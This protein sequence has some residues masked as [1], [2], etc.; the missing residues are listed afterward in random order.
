MKLR[1]RAAAL[2]HLDLFACRGMPGIR[3]PMPH[4]PGSDCV[5]EI[6]ELGSGVEGWV[7]GQRVLVYP[8]FVDYSKGIVEI[9][10]EIA[11]ALASFARCACLPAPYHCR[12]R[13][14][15]AGGQL[16][17][18][19]G[20]AHRM[21]FVRT[22]IRR[23]ETVLVLGASGGVGNAVVLAKLAGARVIA[24]AGSDE[25]CAHLR[26]LGADEMNTAAKRSMPTSDGRR[27]R[28]CAVA[29]VTSS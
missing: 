9:M 12:G 28:C 13:V 27:V 4:V 7:E 17:T 14:R 25:K 22:Q 23:G 26:R 15:R 16:P 19:Y 1:V 2:N 8:P 6:V 21:L 10:G 24:V 5:G 18:A 3:I 29:G 20:T 11:G